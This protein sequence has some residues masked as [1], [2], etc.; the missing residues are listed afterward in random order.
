MTTTMQHPTHQEHQQEIPPGTHCELCGMVAEVKH[1]DQHGVTHYYCR[2]HAPQDA[3]HADHGAMGHPDAHADHQGYDKHAGHSVNMF[4]DKFWVSLILTIPVLLY[5]SMIQEWL[6]FAMPTFPGSTY[7]PLV[8]G[9]VIFFYGGLV[10]IQGVAAELRAKQPGMMTLIALA[11]VVAYTYSVVNTLL[12]HGMDFFWD[13]STL[14]VIML[15]GHWLEMASVSGAQG[16]LQELAKLL[17]DTAELVEGDASR[18]VPVGQLAVG[19]LVRVR[20]GAKIPADGAVVQGQSAVDEAM[21]TGESQAVK[22][23][24]G[25]PVIAGTINSDGTLLLKVTKI[26]EHTAL[27]GI[28]RLVADAQSSK[29]RTQLLADRAAG[30]LFYVALVSGFLT[31]VVWLFVVHADANFTFERV[32]TVFIIACPHALGLAVPLVTSISTSLAAKNGL[33]VRDRASLERAKDIDV[34]LFDK[35]GTLTKGEQGV[36]DVWPEAGQDDQTLLAL[37]AGVEADSEH[38]IARAIVQAARDRQVAPAV[39]TAFTALAGRGVAATVD[40]QQTFIG[41][42]QLLV[43]QRLALSPALQART[44]QAGQE[45]RTVVYV[46]QDTQVVGAL[47]LADVIRPESHE[48]VA[49]LKALKVRMA[50]LTGDSQAVAQYVARELGITE[51]FAEVLPEHKADKVKELQRDGSTVAMVGDGVNDAPALAQA[52][53]GIAIGAGTDVAIESAGIILAKSDPR[54]VVKIIRLS[55]A[56]YA[57]MVQNLVWGAGYNVASIPLA[58]GVLAPLGFILPPVIGAVIMSLSTIIVA[59]NAQLLR[60]VKLDG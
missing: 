18:E 17:P 53:I 4:R 19:A 57:K 9:T 12:L 36:V 39:A 8:L 30:W 60:R 7:L 1:Q 5:S 27:A 6:R 20:P 47:T 3:G 16:A 25:S 37:A 50:M 23:T 32:V 45:G 46:A 48:A 44:A 54:D 33:L 13:L 15:L 55:R 35:T 56:T 42:P 2:H 58:A 26:G 41:G 29:S 49:R 38:S 14:I 21:I 59:F 31:L 34:V 51:L 43:T 24:V 28:M 10:F 52:N 22:K 11:I 40:G